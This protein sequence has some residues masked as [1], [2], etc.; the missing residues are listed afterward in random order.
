MHARIGRGYRGAGENGALCKS[1]FLSLNFVRNGLPL[2]FLTTYLLNTLPSQPV[3][4][5][6]VRIARFSL[7]SRIS[8][9]APRGGRKSTKEVG[10][11]PAY[12]RW[13]RRRD[14]GDCKER[15]RNLRG[16]SEKEKSPYPAFADRVVERGQRCE[17]PWCTGLTGRLLCIE[18]PATMPREWTGRCKRSAKMN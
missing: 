4:S 7:S 15:R 14:G 18:M 10:V 17:A 5:L 9:D 13:T 1:D 6:F 8:L 12:G 3:L 2:L 16:G 11:H